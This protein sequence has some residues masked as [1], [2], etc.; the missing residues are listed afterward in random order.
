MPSLAYLGLDVSSLPAWGPS[1]EEL[2]EQRLWNVTASY[3]D[4][5]EES[6]VHESDAEQDDLIVEDEMDGEDFDALDEAERI[7]AFRRNDVA[8]GDDFWADSFNPFED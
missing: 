2:M 3:R 4:P 8:D 7:E 1:S 5:A 6:S